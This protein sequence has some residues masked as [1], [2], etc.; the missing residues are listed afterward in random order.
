MLLSLLSCCAAELVAAAADP[1][2]QILEE[3]SSLSSHTIELGAAG[4]VDCIG[5]Q[6]IDV[7]H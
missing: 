5:L 2:H 4:E 1:L 7:V 3:Q 6:S